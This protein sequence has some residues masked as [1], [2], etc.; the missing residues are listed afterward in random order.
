MNVKQR[1]LISKMVDAAN[2]IERLDTAMAII[3]GI[4]GDERQRR[5]IAAAIETMNG[6]RD[7]AVRLLLES[8]EVMAGDD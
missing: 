5:G 8:A 1:I 3:E 2:Q 4:D 7:E 6:E